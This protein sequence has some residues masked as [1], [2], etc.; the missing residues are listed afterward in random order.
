MAESDRWRRVEEIFHQALERPDG[1]RSSWL[2]STCG[3][4]AELR[5]EVASLLESDRAAAGGFV[6]S[7]VKRAVMQLHEETQPE[8][9]GR[10][11]GPYR[12]I[13][14]LG[15]GGMGAVYLAERNDQQYES[16]VAIKV[17]RPG[18][19]TDFILRRFRRERQILASLQ[20]PN[21]ARLLDG[22]TADDGT[23]YLVMEFIR[24]SWI[25]KYAEQNSLTVEERL[26][27]F[28]PVCAAVE[29][30]HLHFIVHRD[31][32]PGNI[33]IDESGAPKLLDFG[34]SKLLHANQSDATEPHG[35][36]MM[37]PDYASPEQIVGDP[38]DRGGRMSIRSAPCCT[39]CSAGP[40]RTKLGSARRSRWSALSASRRRS[41][42][43]APSEKNSSRVD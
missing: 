31:L 25:T 10:R 37:T 41:R 35:M 33:L 32:K 43:A 1:E 5:S 42:R 6:G 4:D 12:L 15:R 19:D 23:P 40:A 3:D 21:I 16:E 7:K 34:V 24:G 39:S 36:A 9:E 28:L 8:V 22:G 2:D 20:H 30:A 17:V 14:E 29:Y 27:L 11:V 26:R 38:V 18:L 13:R